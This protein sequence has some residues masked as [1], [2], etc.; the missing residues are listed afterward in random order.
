[1][2]AQ[3]LWDRY[4]EYFSKFE[5]YRDSAGNEMRSVIDELK[6]D[7]ESSVCELYLCQGKMSTN[8]MTLVADLKYRHSELSVL[9]TRARRALIHLFGQFVK[10]PG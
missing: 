3:R 1:M 7:S 4:E 5:D 10:S 6:S 9:S 2:N 8:I